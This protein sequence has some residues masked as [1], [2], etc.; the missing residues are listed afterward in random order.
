MQVA[1][2]RIVDLFNGDV[3]LAEHETQDINAVL[4]QHVVII[5]GVYKAYGSLGGGGSLM[6]A[7]EFWRF[8]KEARL[9]SSSL[10]LSDLDLIFLKANRIDSNSGSADADDSAECVLEVGWP[11]PL[12][13]VLIMPVLRLAT[14]RALAQQAPDT[15][16]VCGVHCEDGSRPIPQGGAR[17]HSRAT[18]GGGAHVALLFHL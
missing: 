16:R 2:D 1:P 10:R 13:R 17:V 5:K 11:W 14:R 3:E 9:P 12:F 4:R 7:H 6:D 8:V 18:R 15:V